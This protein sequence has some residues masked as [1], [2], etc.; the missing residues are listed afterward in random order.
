MRLLCL[1]FG[2]TAQHYVTLFGA[3]YS[4]VIGTTRSPA[5]AA[6]LADRRFGGVAVETIAFD[7]TD[8]PQE[9]AAAIAQANAILVSIAPQDGVDPVLAR[10]R[11]ALEGAPRLGAVV[12]LSSIAVYGDH[13]GRW[14]DESTP[15]N[16]SL[17]RARDRIAAERAW[18]ALGAARGMPVAIVRAAGIYGPGANALAALKGGYARRIVKPG[19]MFNRIHIHDLAQIIEKA[20]ASEA[21]GVFNAADDEPTAPGDPVVFAA[22]L[23]GVAPPP[24]VAFAEARP[25]MSPLNASF[26]EDSRRVRNARIKTV[27]GVTLRYP[28]YRE[29]LRALA[30]EEAQGIMFRAP[31]GTVARTD[32]APTM[33]EQST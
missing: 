31:N 32:N 3:H 21:N 19:Q 16:P 23:L 4:R 29:G 24:E 27:L 13:D 6:T 26:Y 25:T 10:C 17:P 9:L 8:V 28:T 18:Q 11:A 2:Y 1:G 12:Y 7:G 15:L 5:K 33:K 20:F 14:V 22:G 30:A